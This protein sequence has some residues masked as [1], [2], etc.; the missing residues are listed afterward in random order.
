MEIRFRNITVSGKI[1]VGTT[2]LA[3]N[4]YRLLKWK[5][6]NAGVIQRKYDRR[7]NINENKQ[8][9]SKRPDSHEREID[10]MT[11]NML[12]TDKNLIYEAWLSGFMAQG[13]E[14]IFKILLICSDDA[15]RIDR[16]VNRENITVEQAKEWMRQREEQNVSKWHRLYGNYNFW[17]PKYYDLVIDTFSLGPM[18]TAGKVL[19]TI[20]FNKHLKK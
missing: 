17:D 4:L 6:I 11:K 15:V 19:D 9:A 2:T 12:I 7:H 20:G 3:K 10:A 14:E 8:G 13:I 1:A 18:E 16:V 5:Y